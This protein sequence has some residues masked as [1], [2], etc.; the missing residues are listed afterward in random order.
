MKKSKS[1]GKLLFICFIRFKT[2]QAG[3]LAL[4]LL[5]LMVVP[6]VQADTDLRRAIMAGDKGQ[7]DSMTPT[8]EEAAELLLPFQKAAFVKGG[9]AFYFIDEKE[10]Y[11]VKR[12]LKTGHTT[13]VVGLSDVKS[14]LSYGN[15]LIALSNSGKVYVYIQ[16]SKNQALFQIGSK[17]DFIIGIDK[18]KDLLAFTYKGELLIVKGPL[19]PVDISVSSYMIP[20]PFDGKI[21]VTEKFIP[22]FPN[23]RRVTFLST[24][25][26]ILPSPNMQRV[27]AGVEDRTVS[28]EDKGG[29]TMDYVIPPISLDDLKVSF[30]YSQK[31]EH[32]GL[33][34]KKKDGEEYPITHLWIHKEKGNF[35]ATIEYE[36]NQGGWFSWLFNKSSKY[37]VPVSKLQGY[38]G[39]ILNDEALDINSLEGIL[40][41]TGTYARGDTE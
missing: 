19:G 11:L 7:V 24:G 21:I 6:F 12:D 31:V 25:V 32:L 39:F 17:I 1:I 22:V 10:E 38:M 35:Y 33:I 36:V 13:Y 20:K 28:I 37:K 15:Q 9:K 30:D 27:F 8:Q 14:I 2:V 29:H 41:M 23:G 5:A 26:S 4:A 40:L 16:D 18:D 3:A 34:E